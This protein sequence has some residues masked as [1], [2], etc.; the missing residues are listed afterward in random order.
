MFLR[1]KKI[2]IGITG[3]IAAYKIYEL[4]RLLTKEGAVVRTVLT[5]SALNFVSPT[6]LSTLTGYPPFWVGLPQPPNSHRF[7]Q[8]VR[9][10][11]G[12]PRYGEYDFKAG[13]RLGRQ[14]ADGHLV[15]LRQA[16]ADSA[17]RQQRHA[18]RRRR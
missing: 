12:G 15:G 9:R 2:L 10:L 8:V 18:L 5:P 1:G 16:Q 13:L 6:V 4:I 14:S 3:G 7:G 11:S 17:R